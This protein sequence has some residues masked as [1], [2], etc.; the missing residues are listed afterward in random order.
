EVYHD[1]LTLTLKFKLDPQQFRGQNISGVLTFQGCSQ[2]IC[3]R[4]VKVPF[5]FDI[6][7]TTITR[8]SNTTDVNQHGKHSLWG[9]LRARQFEDV[10]SEGVW[11]ALLLTFIAGMITGLSPCVL[12]VIPLTL[13]FIGVSKEVSTRT[14]L[15]HLFIFI[16]GMVVMY[17]FLGIMSVTLGMTLGFVFQQR[18]F[19]IILIVFLLLMAAWLWGLFSLALP[20]SWQNAIVN[21]QP[22]GYLRFFYAGLTIGILATPCVGPLLGPLL[23]YVA[24]HQNLSLGMLLMLSYSLG[25]SA[26]FVVLGFFSNQWIAHFGQKGHIL[27][28]V[29]AVLLLIS[30]FHFALTLIESHAIDE[31]NDHFFENEFYVAQ[32][33]ALDQ[34]KDM[35]V[36]FYADWCAPCQ[37]W[38]EEVWQRKEIQER[39]LKNYV[40]VKINC[41]RETKAC[42]EMVNRYR[43]FGWPT[44]V[45]VN[46]MGIEF[47]QT[48]LV[49]T[50]MDRDDFMKYLEEI[51]RRQ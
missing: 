50:V 13:A 4:A 33:K 17:V 2:R 49:G 21:C 24:A 41:T 27:K 14:K 30:A 32:Q 35:I 34:Q 36:D 10:M 18:F 6:N 1:Q 44:V 48:R 26:L 47:P 29:I 9:L 25:L 38:D 42:L 23:V 7:P 5:S 19:L 43:V 22:R 3:F 31:G 15:F 51:E 20:A 39:V 37:A 12:P 11:I 8:V 28:K 16:I 40:P 46:N 45:F